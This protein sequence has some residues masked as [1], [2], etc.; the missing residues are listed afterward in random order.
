M[1]DFSFLKYDEI[2][3]DNKLNIL[4]KYGNEAKMTD[5]SIM[6]GGFGSVWKDIGNWWTK[7]ITGGFVF[8][9]ST[10]GSLEFAFRTD[11]KIGA[12]PALP[13]SSIFSNRVRGF[14][15][16]KKIEYGEYPQM[17]ADEKTCKELTDQLDKNW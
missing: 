12:R 15:G 10:S 9:V 1:L 16:I 4:K 6:L 13:Y 11:C 14:N 8:A 3:G 5:F 17:V 2:D 7:S